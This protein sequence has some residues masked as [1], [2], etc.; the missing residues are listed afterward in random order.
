M[1]FLE[2]LSMSPRCL[3]GIYVYLLGDEMIVV[4]HPYLRCVPVD[5]LT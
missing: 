4:H 1:S 2:P 5:E 3:S